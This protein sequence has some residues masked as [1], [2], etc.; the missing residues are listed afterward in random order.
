MEVAADADPEAVGRIWHLPNDPVTRTTREIL[1]L[2]YRLAGHDRARISRVTPGLLRTVGLVK[3]AARE[4]VEMLYEFTGP[5]VV[6]SSRITDKLGV[7]ATPLET[8]LAATLD[9]YRR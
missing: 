9:S 8:A 6:D 3:P 7:T 5:F 2:L 4:V 1:D